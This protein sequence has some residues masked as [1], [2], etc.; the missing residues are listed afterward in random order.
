MTFSPLLVIDHEGCPSLKLI[1]RKWSLRRQSPSSPRRLV[2]MWCDWPT[3]GERL[4]VEPV[5]LLQLL[6][7][8][9]QCHLLWAES[10]AEALPPQC[11]TG[12]CRGRG[13]EVAGRQGAL[14]S[15]PQG[16]RM[17]RKGYERLGKRSPG[18]AGAGAGSQEAQRRREGAG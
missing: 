8:P 6:P 16:K 13:R 10:C 9:A 18:Y 7:L 17:R 14:V 15:E 11:M 12:T 3:L 1:S 2:W 5:A 4:I